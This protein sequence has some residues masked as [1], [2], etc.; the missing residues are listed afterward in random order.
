MDDIRAQLVGCPGYEDGYRC[1]VIP[2]LHEIPRPGGEPVT[3]ISTE[4]GDL[5]CV[6]SHYV[7]PR[8]S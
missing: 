7:R 8:E 5:L 4:A 6:P 3:V 2:G 1:T